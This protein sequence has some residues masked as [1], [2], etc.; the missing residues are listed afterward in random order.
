MIENKLTEQEKRK[1]IVSELDKNIFVEAGA[2]AGKTTLIV[3]RIINQLKHGLL[4][5]EIVAITFTNA[6]ARELKERVVKE[7]HKQSDFEGMKEVI[8]SIDQMQI[9][10]IHS[11]CNR[12]LK[13]RSLD[14]GMPMELNLLKEEE[15]KRL[16]D[17]CFLHF[18]EGL[19][20]KD[21]DILLKAGKYKKSVLERLRSITDQVIA[22]SKDTNFTVSLPDVDDVAFANGAAPYAAYVQNEIISDIAYVYHQNAGS[23][24]QISDEYLTSYGKKIVAALIDGNEL[25]IMKL[26]VNIPDTVSYIIKNPSQKYLIENK[27]ADKKTAKE[28]VAGYTE[29]LMKLRTYAESNAAAMN[30]LLG[31]YEN[32]INRPYIEYAKQAADYF[33]D[34]LPSGVLYN[35]LLIQKTEELLKES[36]EARRYLAGKFKC[37]YV[38]EFQDTDHVQ[39]NLIRLICRDEAGEKL[40]DGAL[41]VVGDPKQSIYRF[42]GAEPDVYFSTKADM[43][44]MENAVVLE[45]ADNYRSNEL[46]ID[47]VNKEYAAKDITP[48]SPYIPMNAVKKIPANVMTADVIAGV[49]KYKNPIAA[50]EGCCEADAESIKDLILNLTGGNHTIVD[51]DEQGNLYTRKIRYSDFLIMCAYMTDMDIYADTLKRYGIPL[52]MDSKTDLTTNRVLNNFCKIYEWLLNPYVKEN[53]VAVSEKFQTAGMDENTADKLIMLLQNETESLSDSGKLIYLRNHINLLFD[54]DTRYTEDEVADITT[55][56]IQMTEMVLNNTAANG[57]ALLDAMKVYIYTKLEHQLVMDDSLD[58]VRF[59]NLHKAKGLEGN[60][61]IWAN[62]QENATFRDN[63]F[64]EGNNFYPSITYKIKDRDTLAWVG[65]NRDEAVRTRAAMADA[66]EKIRL[67]YVACTRAK[68]AFI[69]MDRLD[70]KSHCL[71]SEGYDLELLPSVDTIIDEHENILPVNTF[72]V[73]QL[74]I[75]RDEMCSE[76]SK[77][78]IF[79]SHS[80]SEFEDESAG[81][82]TN[83]EGQKGAMAR[84]RGGVFGTV[85]HRSLELLVNRITLTKEQMD[86]AN[87]DAMKII[88]AS[89]HQAISENIVN[90]PSNE[91]Q[92]YETFIHEVLMAY[93]KWWYAEKMNEKI[94]KT[95]TELPFSFFYED[96]GEG[97]VWMHGTADLVLLMKDGSYRIIDY[98]SDVDEKYADEES[99]ESRLRG[100]YA[101]QILAYK[102]SISTIM[103]TQENNITA[104][105]VSFSQ[106]D[107]AKGE[108]LRVRVTDL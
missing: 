52:V 75:L 7:V 70:A 32:Y 33:F 35:D 57:I 34:R 98:K 29:E 24:D 108:K 91:L 84:P 65:Y 99:F 39:E 105:I 64:R 54:M 6:A 5:R 18:A 86:A 71:F 46:I 30:N 36:E 40:R 80:P 26:M 41:F 20:R 9:S 59:M 101:G 13:E 19:S 60:I 49:Y 45:L 14:A 67:E 106:K 51:Y 50:A 103:N 43:S 77:N 66:A 48:G 104:K 97:N 53:R 79:T 82:P 93:G 15:I 16:K 38:D 56:V 44:A 96:A 81:K 23:L 69:F 88:D 58:A 21:W 22:A 102:K 47:W 68:Q 11:F 62:R 63:A 73:A 61:V 31:G 42:R 90:I 12:L 95:Y 74:D 25:E 94:E 17:D 85:M 72:G 100:K 27:R 8:T 3:G 89:Y 37:I 1:L 10:T 55:K 83:D 92:D 76:E 87:L 78:P 107:V 2:G 4:P 28:E